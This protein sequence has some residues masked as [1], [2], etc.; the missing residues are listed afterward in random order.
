MCTGRCFA[1]Q[2]SACAEVAV[3]SLN[4]DLIDK[5]PIY[6]Q[7][8]VAVYWAVDLEGRRA[9]SHSSPRDGRYTQLETVD[10]HGRLID[11]QL[12]ITV[13]LPELFTAAAR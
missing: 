2:P 13:S 7:A 10:A 11:A 12:G 9:V 6:A 3:S 8:G 1:P 4:R 5:P